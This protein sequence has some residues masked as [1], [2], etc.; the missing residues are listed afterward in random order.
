MNIITTP[1]PYQKNTGEI[2]SSGGIPVQ[3]PSKGLA[4]VHIRSPDAA[5]E[6]K[7]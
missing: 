4:T 6:V 2:F 3:N 7:Q 1:T 5:G